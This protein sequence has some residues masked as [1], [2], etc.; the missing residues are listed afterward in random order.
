MKKFL[1]T[2][3]ISAF[4]FAGTTQAQDKFEAKI[5]SVKIP[6]QKNKT[7][8]VM[9][10]Q[11][12][13]KQMEGAIKAPAPLKND[14]K[15]ARD[16]VSEPIKKDVETSSVENNKESVVKPVEPK[17]KKISKKSY[18]KKKNAKKKRIVK[19]DI[20]R[21]Y[22]AKV[23]PPPLPSFKPKANAISQ[24]QKPVLD[25]KNLPSNMTIDKDTALRIAL[26]YAPPARSF[27]VHENRTYKGKNVYQISFKTENGMHDI[28]V[29]SE[30]GRVLKK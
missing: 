21:S 1:F 22:T 13:L 5:D 15:E 24:V 4:L 10:G 29:D 9:S 20:I 16:I 11:D 28:L 6:V 27:T 2:L 3:S 30:S 12:L 23:G 17:P 25:Y 7:A 19:K 14:T 26:E 18:N 8:P